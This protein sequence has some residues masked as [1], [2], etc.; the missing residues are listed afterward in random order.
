MKLSAITVN[1]CGKLLP[2]NKIY[3]KE[4]NFV[5][6]IP[7]NF[8]LGSLYPPQCL[9][10][11]T[12]LPYASQ[13]KLDGQSFSDQTRGTPKGLKSRPTPPWRWHWCLCLPTALPL[14]LWTSLLRTR[15][16]K[17]IWGL[18]ILTKRTRSRPEMDASLVK[19]WLSRF[20]VSCNND[21]NTNI[22]LYFLYGLSGIILYERLAFV[23]A[24]EDEIWLPTA[25]RI[26]QLN[27]RPYLVQWDQ[28]FPL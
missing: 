14:S 15:K 7:D 28:H 22:L 23:S 26:T 16:P 9:P 20:L 5:L 19:C 18:M 12:T 11:S 3:E 27:N 8:S 10:K 25:A 21:A 2:F 4:D 6:H 13:T 17:H 1:L 24:Q